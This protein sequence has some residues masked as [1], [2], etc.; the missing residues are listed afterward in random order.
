MAKIGHLIVCENIGRDEEKN[1]FIINP[2]A[3]FLINETKT[4]LEFVVSMG[5]YDLPD[6]DISVTIEV[7]DPNENLISKREGA[8]EPPKPKSGDQKRRPFS[9]I[10]NIGFKDVLIQKEGEYTIK[11]IIDGDEKTLIIPIRLRKEV[12]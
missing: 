4:N 6:S 10:V 9:V 12:D 1:R 2:K 7:Y 5:I 11:A 3:T 8:S